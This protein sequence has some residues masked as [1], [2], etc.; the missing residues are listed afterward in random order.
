MTSRLVDVDGCDY[1]V[2]NRLRDVAI[3]FAAQD[4]DVTASSDPD[5]IRTSSDSCDDDAFELPL[6]VATCSTSDDVTSPASRFFP[7]R[8]VCEL[9]SLF[10]ILSSCSSLFPNHRCYS[11]LIRVPATC[12][13]ELI[14][15]SFRNC[16]PLVCK[17]RVTSD[18]A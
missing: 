12:F 15:R 6:G 3:E 13:S 10:S 18:L 2:I 1:L 9:S 14:P 16:F 5:R 4:D 11:C 17:L 7:R 8:A